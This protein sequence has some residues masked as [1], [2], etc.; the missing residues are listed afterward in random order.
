MINNGG[1]SPLPFYT[2]PTRDGVRFYDEDAYKLVMPKNRLIPFQVDVRKDQPITSAHLVRYADGAR[3]DVLSDL[4]AAGLQ[5]WVGDLDNRNIL[6]FPSTQDLSVSLD[7]GRYMLELSD[8]EVYYYSEPIYLVNDVSDY[9]KLE[10]SSVTPFMTASAQLQFYNNFKFWLYID[11]RLSSPKY[12]FEEVATKR[13]GYTF[14]EKQISQKVY[15]FEFLAPE[16]ICDAL[17]VVRMCTTKNITSY[18]RTLEMQSFLMDA[19]FLDGGELATLE[20]EF[21]V[22]SVI[23]RTEEVIYPTLDGDFNAD[24]NPD[25]Y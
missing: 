14:I 4:N 19:K 21:E 15:K 22:D 25:Y 13:D 8:G 3:I 9:L 23:K 24:H 17:R 18:D 10:Y 1:L 7:T 5:R 12:D 6:L 20:C 2:K 16:H 11:S